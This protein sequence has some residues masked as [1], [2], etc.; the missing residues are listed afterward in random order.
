[1]SISSRGKLSGAIKGD[2]EL[3]G[4]VGMGNQTK[5]AVKSINGITPDKN[6]NV[7]IEI[8]PNGLEQLSMLIEADMLPAVHDVSGAI[9]TNEQGNIILRY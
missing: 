2:S 6:G 5:G 4:F 7:E 1:M 8:V 3:K 9:L